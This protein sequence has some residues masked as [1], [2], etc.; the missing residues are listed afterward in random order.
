MPIS[1]WA[2]PLAVRVVR[3]KLHYFLSYECESEPNT[4]LS[5]PPAFAGQSFS[6]RTKLMQNS[7]LGR[8]DYQLGARRPLHARAS[9]W[10]WGNP[11]TQVSGTEHPSQAADRRARRSMW[12]APGPRC[13]ARRRSRRCKFS[14]SH[15]DW[16]NLLAEAA[17]RQYS[18]SSVPGWPHRRPAAQLP[19]GVLPEHLRVRYDLTTI[20]ARTTS[21]SA[22]STCAGMTPGS[23]SCCR[24]ASSSLPFDPGGP[25]DPDSRQD[26]YND[27]SRWDLTG[28]DSTV[29]RFDHELRRLDHR[30]S[31]ADHMPCGSGT[32]GR[33]TTR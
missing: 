1:R 24:V 5:A 3:N 9:Y 33:S 15:F 25:G 13:S 11:F 26:A 10:D 7:F 19:A 8:V 30:H 14:Y 12:R 28:L 17:A 27:P 32:P 20:A 29:G 21:R 31:A 22:P 6:F 16:K 18:E 23:G 4:I 2:P